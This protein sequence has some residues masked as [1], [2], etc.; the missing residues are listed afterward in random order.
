VAVTISDI[1][2]RVGVTKATVSLVLNGKASPVRISQR[3]RERVLSAARELNYRPSFP[4]KALAEGRTWS[5]GLVIGDVHTPHFSELAS[6]ALRE[7]SERGYHLLISVTEWDADKELECVDLLLQ[8]GVDGILMCTGA[9]APGTRQYEYMVRHNFPVVLTEREDPVLPNIRV[10]WSSG[11]L[12]AIAH[13]T[14]RQRRRAAFV[15]QADVDKSTYLKHLGYLAACRAHRIEP[16]AYDCSVHI[17]DARQLGLR[18]GQEENPPQA[19]IVY[20]D[21]LAA[22]VIRGLR[23]AGRHIPDDVAVVGMDGTD[24][25]AYGHLPLTSIATDRRQLAVRGVEMLLEMIDS[26]SIK[27]DQI[28]LP[29]KLI[30]RESA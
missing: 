29:T 21:Y 5:L 27:T 22:G 18:I 12:E 10:D 25:G 24:M 1:A 2:A 9:L 11:M 13:L 3:T 16:I 8:R 23:Q 30:V 20:S 4:A 19:V 6:I 28:V 15:G 7:A 14:S 26:G 17:E